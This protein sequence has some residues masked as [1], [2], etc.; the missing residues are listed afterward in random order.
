M[1]PSTTALKKILSTS[2]EESENQTQPL[3]ESS[4]MSLETPPAEA[5]QR[6]LLEC[7]LRESDMMLETSMSDTSTWWNCWTSVLMGSGGNKYLQMTRLLWGRPHINRQN[8]WWLCIL[9]PGGFLLQ[10]NRLS[11][12]QKGFQMG[13]KTL[14]TINPVNIFIH[15]HWCFFVYAVKIIL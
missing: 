14:P 4:V 8:L 3:E 15:C 11:W 1:I 6:F 10:I 12:M 2:A 5:F 13:R 7:D 9:H